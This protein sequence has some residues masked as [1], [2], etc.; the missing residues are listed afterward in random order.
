M[1]QPNYKQLL[2]I[3]YRNH[4]FVPFV[5]SGLS[6]SFGMPKWKELLPV[7]AEEYSF[8]HIEKEKF[9]TAL[10]DYRYLDAVD[11]II[12]AG[13]DELDLQ[14]LV[15]RIIRGKVS[16]LSDEKYKDILAMFKYR[17]INIFRVFNG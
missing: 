9:D 6:A 2:Q 1:F 15:A 13:V 3:A 8:Y 12:D 7:L 14:R 5:G 11:C 4:M 17:Y 10:A 16:N